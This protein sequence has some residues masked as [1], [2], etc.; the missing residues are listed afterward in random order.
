MKNRDGRYKHKFSCLLVMR[1]VFFGFLIVSCKSQSSQQKIVDEQFENFYHRFHLD[2][3]FQISRIHF[4]LPGIKADDMQMEDTAY[5]WKKEDWEVHRDM[6][7]DTTDFIV[8]K[9]ISDSLAHEK[10][11]K[12]NSGFIV[13]RTFRKIEGLWYLVFYKDINL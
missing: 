11:Y 12:E 4:P 13:E 9:D 5:Y 1:W 2:S 7:L 10:I 3:A 8:E 6:N